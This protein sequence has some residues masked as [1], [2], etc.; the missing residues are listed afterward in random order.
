[1][2][3]VIIEG[4]DNTGKDTLIASIKDYFCDL[5]VKEIHCS[6][7]KHK[8]YID[9]AIE[10]DAYFLELVDNIIENKYDVD[11]V[12]FNRAWYGEYVYGPIYR[13]RNCEDVKKVIL[14]LEEKL[15]DFDVSYI[16]LLSN[17]VSFLVKN[18][19]GKSLANNNV[20]LM[21]VEYEHFRQ[22]FELSTIK[23]KELIIVNDENGKFKSKKYILDIALNTINK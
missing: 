8:H 4:T 20:N 3:I 23:K 21:G 16:Q 6:T 10:Q 9:A 22:V 12:I 11:V 7:P 5:R 15:K 14:R 17:N 18:D 1:M 13:Y 19:D 2:K